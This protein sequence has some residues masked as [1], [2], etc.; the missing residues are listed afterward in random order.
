MHL[1]YV[2]TSTLN[3]SMPPELAAYIAALVA[4]GRYGTTSEI[5]RAGLRLLQD[6][7]D[8]P[9]GTLTAGSKTGTVRGG[10]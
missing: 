2:P 10:H 9:P 7:E 6:K 4:S 1:A 8:V 3:I 5:I